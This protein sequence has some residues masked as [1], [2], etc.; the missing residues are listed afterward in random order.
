MSHAIKGKSAIVTGAG[1][2]IN[3]AFAQQLLEGGCNVLIADL[4][5]RPEAQRL[6]D[7]H[8][9]PAEG[10][11][12]AVYQHTDVT[13]WKHLERMFAEAEAQF[14]EIDIVCPG[15]GVYEPSFSSFWYPPGTPKSRDRVEGGRYASVDI[16]LV[17]PI[18]TTQ[19][20]L[21]RFLKYKRK[22]RTVVIISS[23]NAQDTC[24]STP[25]Y[26]ATKHATSGFVRAMSKIDQVHVRIAAVAPGIIKTPLFMENPDKLAM[27]DGD[28]DILVEPSEVATVMVCLIER[29]TICSKIDEARTGA[30]DIP[31]GSGTILEVTKNR[32]RAVNAYHDPGPSGPGA[33]GSNFEASEGTTLA[34]LCPGWGEPTIQKEELT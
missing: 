23:T 4:S 19:L 27:L 30:Q 18:R 15:A 34:L 6:V 33:V 5:L 16:N 25:I 8:A 31:I 21:A 14:G 22:P 26:D 3:L 29:D 20:A 11:A 13:N 17:H 28:K 12:R 9:S 1:S 32:V 10:R 24:L 2:G 7:A